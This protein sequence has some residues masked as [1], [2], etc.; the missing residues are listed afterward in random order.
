MR[1][2]PSNWTGALLVCG[3]CSRKVDGG[4]GKKGR[5]PLAKALRRA[6]GLGKGR[7]AALGV[8]ETPCL[9]LCPKRAVVLVD[10]RTPGYWMVVPE[11]G[12]LDDL[13]AR[14]TE[15]VNQM[16]QRP[17]GRPQGGSGDA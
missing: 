15:R 6:L 10:T 5:T 16:E 11:G 13:G 8:V 1:R 17:A 4:F 3:K 9:K 7:K 12:D 14:L 2:V